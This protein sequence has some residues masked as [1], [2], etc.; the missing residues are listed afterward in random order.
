MSDSLSV[1]SGLRSMDASSRAAT[2]EQVVAS[3]DPQDVRVLISL[4]NDPSG[5]VVNQA[6]ELLA[7]R[8]DS[9]AIEPLERFA[10][11][12]NRF[13]LVWLARYALSV[14][15]GDAP[16]G[17]PGGSARRAAYGPGL[18]YESLTWNLRKSKE[19]P[20]TRG[21]DFAV[22]I[23]PSFHAEM[24]V[25]IGEVDARVW[26]GTESIWRSFNSGSG[27]P[28]DAMMNVL[29]TDPAELA[30]LRGFA[31][32]G[33]GGTSSPG[34]DG[35]QFGRIELGD[36]EP[37]E[38]TSWENPQLLTF[39]ALVRSLGLASSQHFL[40]FEA[41]ENLGVYVGIALETSEIHSPLRAV[42]LSGRCTEESWTEFERSH[43]D[44]E[45]DVVDVSPLHFLSP[46][47]R[48]EFAEWVNRTGA[49]L[50]AEEQNLYTSI[51]SLLDKTC[52]SWHEAGEMLVAR[53]VL[54]SIGYWTSGPHAND[55]LPHPSEFVDPNADPG[56][57][58]LIADL[59]DAGVT[60]L[61]AMGLS[62]CRICGQHNGAG[63]NTNGVFT[64]PSGLS[65][66]VREHSV[67]LPTLLTNALRA[68]Q[69][70]QEDR[71]LTM[72][73]A[74]A[75]RVSQDLWRSVMQRN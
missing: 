58:A 1:S 67:V 39:L 45:L 15:R 66:Y 31:I 2:Y 33:F 54:E 60:Y 21:D 46:T 53:P 71:W 13:D 11:A 70:T 50:I 57:Q 25:T 51:E 27:F 37:L 52:G 7:A 42:R 75:C 4:L 12:D 29:T 41:Y 32:G 55:G 61:Y 44:A 65:H 19:N 24:I 35:V 30:E 59:L 68:R 38:T 49:V 73:A 28:S 69:R 26:I 9:T 14:I 23:L 43:R 56:A 40:E 22:V 10:M 36:T 16:K 62:P 17:V 18:V 5:F 8:P 3:T 47:I 48:N 20:Q 72:F 34:I 6:L 74:E 63:E 64:W